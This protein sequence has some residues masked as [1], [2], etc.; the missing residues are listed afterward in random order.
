MPEIELDEINALD[1]LERADIKY[2][3]IAAE[4]PQAKIRC[5]F[6]DDETPS[7]VVYLDSRMFQ[8]R[9]AGC[10]AHGDLIKLL[11]RKKKVTRHSIIEEL[12]NRYTLV[13]DKIVEPAVI[14]AWH[15]ALWEH[16]PSLA[17]LRKRGVTNEDIREARIGYSVEERRIT[18]PVRVESGVFVQCKK[19]K[20]GAPSREKMRMMRGR[21]RDLIYQVEQLA[22]FDTIMLC[23]G[24]L[25]ALV[26]K[27]Q[28]NRHGI[29]AI[30]PIEGEGS[31]HPDF[32]HKIAGKHIIV[33]LDVDHGGRTE[34]IAYCAKL[35]PFVA[36][37]GI[38]TLPL[39]TQKFPTGDINDF[40]GPLVG[41]NLF[42]VIPSVV[43]WQPTE[44][45]DAEYETPEPATLT[46]AMQAINVGRRVEIT[47]ILAAV[48]QAPYA[49]PKTLNVL[50]TKNED[51][52]GACPVTLHNKS[53]WTIKAESKEL[54]SFVDT[55]E[56]KHP[57]YMQRALEIPTAC[58]VC[59]FEVKEHYHAEITRVSP[60]S[61]LTSRDT[62]RNMQ[63]AIFV[64]NRP[65]EL[66]APYKFVGRMFPHPRNAEATLVISE[67]EP[68]QDSLATYQCTDLELLEV[69][70]PDEW[71]VDGIQRKLDDIYS[72][73]EANVT[74]IYQRRDL[75][76]VNDLF[77]HSPLF[78]KF[79]NNTVN[80]WVQ[81]LV[82]GDTAQG[83]SEISCGSASTGRR[84]LQGHYDL[85][86]KVECKNA[87]VAGLIGG[88]MHFGTKWLVAWGK[89]PT[90]DKGAV[91]L[92]E[93]KGLTTQM[94]GQLTD[95][96]S[97]GE[98]SLIKIEKRTTSARTRGL[99]NTNTRDG[100]NGI[101]REMSQYNFG[102]EA[103]VELIGAL[104]DT[105]R[106]DLFYIADKN[107]VDAAVINLLDKDRPHVPHVYTSKL[108]RALVLWAWTRDEET[109]CHFEDEATAEVMRQA[110][111][112]C[113]IFHE[114]IPIVDRGSMRYK[115]AKLAA[116]L[117][118]RTFSHT[119][120]A[121]SLL[122]RKCHVEYVSQFLERIYSRQSFGYLDYS[123]AVQTATTL[124][125]AEFIARRFETMPSGEDV[126][127]NMLYAATIELQD[128]QD[129]SGTDRNISQLL[130]SFLVQ[131]NA[132]VREARHYRKSAPFIALLRKLLDAGKFQQVPD[133]IRNMEP[134]KEEF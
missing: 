110:T 15:A 98:A 22:L 80:G 94:I 105:R 83:K 79:Q 121:E 72:D 2:D 35:F 21:R 97:S 29:G 66:N 116:S 123:K 16:E 12:S 58:R 132:L 93:A 55:D 77:Y 60:P 100:R 62:E 96:R 4:K 106:F 103:I 69:F 17:E 67:W 47:G 56:N 84:G 44:H 107:D 7:A 46:N 82:I 91:I 95:M 41:G 27:R 117:A 5:P 3:L 45:I 75:H 38:L 34:A 11:A 101:G 109:Q 119:D 10:K 71:T 9:A 134:P 127:R 57:Q 19:Y 86:E 102:V 63:P 90:N 40:V 115:L 113:G 112:L 114:S 108:C 99:W 126:C 104:E 133:H 32:N 1:E 120:D 14:E 18:I 88:L 23:G 25:K 131:K 43:P 111:R 125:D 48:G 89:I 122:V 52:C 8:C 26:A 92:E 74:K 6:H 124:K 37:I 81:A 64:G 73:F 28:L 20:P 54:L 36:S 128:L 49:I 65:L 42:D 118:C 85:G 130:L 59:S 24:E 53:E 129:W 87:T 68:T 76:L 51:C 31:W 13:G 61:L 70:K 78:I 30:S 39:D 33:C 50:C